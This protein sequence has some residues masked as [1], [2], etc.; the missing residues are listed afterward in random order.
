MMFTGSETNKLTYVDVKD[1]ATLR[2]VF[3]SGEVWAV[4]CHAMNSTKPLTPNFEAVAH[5]L[6]DEMK[7]AV[8]DCKAALPS[9]G[10][11]TM[12]RWKL[13]PHPQGEPVLFIANGVGVK[14]LPASASRSEYDLVRE[15][16]LGAM[17]KPLPVKNTELLREKCLYKPRCLVVLKGGA[18]LEP[19]SEKALDKLAGL[20][21]AGGAKRDGTSAVAFV[22][23]DS[24]DLRLNFEGYAA[25]ED[26]KLRRFEALSHRAIYFR[27]TSAGLFAL[28]HKGPLNEA[29]L[30]AFLDGVS[31]DA[32]AGPQNK[33]LKPLVD[34]VTVGKRKAPKRPPA[35]KA[36][37]VK[38]EPLPK[39]GATL[40]PEDRERLVKEQQA[41]ERDRREQMDADA[42]ASGHIMEETDEAEAEESGDAYA[43]DE[44]VEELD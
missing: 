11:T 7:F 28:A 22:E 10:K 15:F 1:E 38:A 31:G 2:Q 42:A 44:D 24:Q 23:M 14:Q 25:G 40:S 8:L 16:R 26:I 9:S 37:V 4:A 19:Q 36:K 30:G 32:D 20:H 18:E 17:R 5:R 39:S 21:A 27:N 12:Q 29:S 41:R 33:R 3:F 13:L 43:D 6:G 35:P 34:D